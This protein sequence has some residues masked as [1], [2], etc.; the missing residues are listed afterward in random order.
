MSPG[1]PLPSLLLSPPP[2]RALQG[3]GPGF[4]IVRWSISRHPL[5]QQHPPHCQVP[6]WVGP[7]SCPPTGLLTCLWLRGEAAGGCERGRCG[8]VRGW[9]GGGWRSGWRS[10]DWAT[11]AVRAGL[12]L[13][14]MAL[15]LRPVLPGCLYPRSHLLCAARTHLS[16][17][18]PPNMFPG[19]H[20]SRPSR[21]AVGASCLL[22]WASAQLREPPLVGPPPPWTPR[23]LP[24][25]D[26]H[27]GDNPEAL[28]A[29]HSSLHHTPHGTRRLCWAVA[30][31]LLGGWVSSPEPWSPPVPRVRHELVNLVT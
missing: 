23:L 19:A 24:G 3:L 5:T 11:H 14:P 15:P 26:L 28:G 9:V 2:P 25:R 4:R 31:R 10:S 29:P 7:L 22:V 27:W 21:T 8:G 6:P 1:D 13:K 30:L 18:A 16:A 17:G 20:P 12:R